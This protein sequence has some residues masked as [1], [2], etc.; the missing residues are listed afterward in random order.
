MSNDNVLLFASE[1]VRRELGEIE[2]NP[3]SLAES[4]ENVGGFDRQASAIVKVFKKNNVEKIVT[5]AAEFKISLYPF[6]RGCNWGYGSKL[7]VNDGAILLDLSNLNTIIAINEAHGVATIEP[8][9]T[10]IQLAHELE[11]RKS[12]YF[13]D[14]TGSG[15]QTSVLGNALERGIAYGSLRVQQLAG[16]EVVLAD[17]STLRTGFGDYEN[18]VLAGLYS[19][20]LGPSLDGLFFQSNLGIVTEGELQLSLRP[21]KLVAVSVS[22][23]Q[24]NLK[25]FVDEIAELKKQVVIH[26]IPHLADRERML[27]TLAPLV[28]DD[29]GIDL[30]KARTMIEKVVNAD[31]VLTTSV[32][33]SKEIVKYKIREL[34]KRVS[35]LGKIYTHDFDQPN[36]KKNIENVFLKV[37]ASKEQQFVIKASEQLRGFHQGKPSDAGIRF[38]L[39]NTNKIVDQN[40]QGFLLCT[41]LAPLSGESAES[42]YKL[43]QECSLF[44]N[45]QYAMTQNMINDRVLEAVISVHFDRRS[46]VET[47]NAH[48]FINAMNKVFSSRGFYPYRINIDQ[49]AE[50]NEK[51]N[52]LNTVVRKIKQAL[53]PQ[54]VIAPGRYI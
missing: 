41:P 7:P 32:S 10:Q 4:L 51:L 28:M 40:A 22:I 16:I 30:G 24:K 52:S 17:G 12:R 1:F 34:K 23:S 11:K 2:L 48:A 35:K 54:G 42:F 46:E 21:E 19:Y 25:V 43:T 49:Q 45:V 36:W 38:L 14:V 37:L 33:G 27:S 31:W 20:G 44:Y 29:V 47:K 15:K 13:L 39:D 50:R 5:L 53:D 18:P 8:G 6:S 26:G 9:V 3:A